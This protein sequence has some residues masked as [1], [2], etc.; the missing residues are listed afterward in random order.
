MPS[1]KQV[2]VVSDDT[3]MSTGKMISQACH[4]SLKAAEK[5]SDEARGEWESSGAKKVALSAGGKSLED[6]FRQAKRNKLPAYLVK[7]AGLTEVE[8]GTKTAL[9]IGPAEESK[10]DKITGELGLIE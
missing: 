6:L 4:A 1:Y 10:I 9:G 2:I 5:A 3:G 7:D 8:S